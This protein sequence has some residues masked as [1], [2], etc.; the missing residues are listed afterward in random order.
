MN[1][2]VIKYL[3]LLKP[4]I[5]AAMG[6]DQPGDIAHDDIHGEGMYYNRCYRFKDSH[7][8]NPL[9]TIGHR[10]IRIPL[11]LPLP[12]QQ[13]AGRSLW[14]M[15][16]WSKFSLHGC[17]GTI[18]IWT[19]EPA[20]DGIFDYEGPPYLA[21]LNTCKFGCSNPSPTTT[22]SALINLSEYKLWLH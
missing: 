18:N 22:L 1:Q 14:E 13:E 4:E 17:N 8:I 10:L 2:Q 12:G 9:S 11:P 19:H 5:D 20:K 15:V 3:T 16:D 21:L 7:V 6:D